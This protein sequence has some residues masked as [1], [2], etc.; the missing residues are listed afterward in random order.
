[1]ENNFQSNGKGRSQR[2]WQLLISM[3]FI[4][5]MGIGQMWADQTWDFTQMSDADKTAY[6]AA[7]AA[8]TW[9]SNG[10]YNSQF[11]ANNGVWTD[12][13]STTITQIKNFKFKRSGSNLGTG[14]VRVYKNASGKSDGY[15]GY[16]NG[17]VHIG[18]TA[19][20]GDTVI[21][22]YFN[23]ESS[24]TKGYVLTGLKRI[25]DNATTI[26][27]AARTATVDSL[28]ATATAV[29]I[30]AESS[31]IRLYKLELKN[32]VSCTK[33]TAPVSLAVDSK[34]HNTATLSWDPLGAGAN[35]YKIALVSASGAGT[36]DWKDWTSNTY[37]AKDL[38]PET[39]YTFKVKYKGSGEGVCD[40]SDEVTKSFT[41]DPD[42]A[43]TTYKVTLVPAGGTISDATGWTLNA[44]N[45]EKEVSEGTVLSLPTFTKENRTFKTWRNGVP[46]DVTSPIT[47][48]AD[49]TLTAVWN[50]TVDNVIYYWAGAQGGA[51]EVGGTATGSTD[52][53]I[54]VAKS[55]YYCLQINGNT[56]YDKYV[57][58]TL[59][60]EEKVKTGDKIRY[61]GFYTNTGTKN[62]AIKMRTS[63]G[64]A[65]FTGANLPRVETTSP[66]T[67]TY[68][69]ETDG[70]NASAVQITRHQTQTSSWIPM[71]QI[72]RPTLVEEVNVRTVTFNYN[73]GGTT[74]N[75]TVNVASGSAVYAPFV[76][77]WAH[78][79]F[80][81]WKLNSSAYDFSTPVTSDITLVADW[82]QLYT[83][84]FSA[85]DGS[86]DAP[87]AVADKAQGETFKV[88]ANTFTAPDESKEFDKWNDGTNDYAPDAT[89]TVGTANVV[90]TAQWKSASA[91]YTVIFKDGTTE[92]GVKKFNVST[93]PSDAEIDKAKPLYTFAAWQKDAADIALD[94]AFWATV[95][96]D[97]EVTLTAR[98]AKAYAAN[99]DFEAF[100]DAQGTSGNWQ[101]YLSTNNY[102][103]SNTADVSLDDQG[104]EKPAD[105][106][107]KMKNHSGA[108]VSF[109][110][111]ADKLVLVK[112]GRVN[113]MS[114]SVDG[115]TNYS[116]L[117]GAA[118]SAGASVVNYLYNAVEAEYRLK[119]T[120]D[121]Y[122]IIQ[123]IT[124]TNPYQVSYDSHGA[125]AIAAQYGT[126]SV[127]L[128]T[129]VNGTG[130][131][132]G[133]YTAATEG[134]KIGNAG[135]SYTPTANITLHAQWETVSSDNT[136]SD[137]KVDGVTVAGFD[138][139]VHIYYLGAYEY[140]QHPEITSAT[141]TAEAAGAT[142]AISNTPV[143]YVDATNDFWYVQ[144]NV[145]PV[146]GTPIGYNQVRYTVKPKQ[147]VSL[148]KVVIPNG[149]GN[150]QNVAEA[151]ITGYI[152]GTAVQK[153]ESGTHKLGSKGHYI[154]ITLASGTFQENDI[155]NV[156]IE[157]ITGDKLR[158]FSENT[159]AESK[160]VAQSTATMVAG[161][162]TV[163]LDATST[164]SLYLRRG[165]DAEDYQK[166]W[167]PFVG[168]FE[169][170]R[171]MP[172]FIESF[173]LAGVAGIIDQ[174]LKTISVEVPYSTDITSLT[175][176]IKAWANGGATLDKTGAQN[177]S[178]AVVYKVTSA[179]AE[180]G[181]VAYTV[182]VTKAEASHVAT[183]SDIKLDG[184]SL[185]GFDPATLSYNVELEKGTLA[186][187]A[188]TYTAA[189]GAT[190]IPSSE[191]FPGAYNLVV[192]AEDGTT[193]Q[194]YTINF[195]V[196][197]KNTVVIFDGTAATQAEALKASPDATGA[198]W[199]LVGLSISESA[200]TGYNY[201]IATGGQT[202]T[203][204]HIVVTVP[205]NYLP[206][207][208]ITHVTNSNGSA[209]N[210][211][212]G[213]STTR[214]ASTEA[215]LFYVTSSDISNPSTG[216]SAQLNEETTYYIHSDQSIN[217]LKIAL[218]LEPLAPKAATPTLSGL[219]DLAACTLG[220]D[221]LTV[222]ASDLDG[223][224]AHYQWYKVV[225][226]DDPDEAVG[227]DANT[228]APAVA[229]N[230][231]VVV[232]NQKDGCRDNSKKSDE[233]TVSVKAATEI[234]GY[235]N[236]NGPEGAT[237]K[238]ISVTATGTGTLH[239]VWYTCNDEFGTNPVAVDPANDAATLSGLT[240]PSGIQYYKV[241]V[242]GECGSAEQ[243]LFA[244]EWADVELE[245][246]TNSVVWN[247]H[248][249][250]N[251]AAWTGITDNVDIA[252]TSVLANVNY[253]QIP[254]VADFHS[255]MLKAVVGTV[256]TRMRPSTDNGCYQGDGIMFHTTVPG[257][258]H[259]T[260]RGTG[261][262]AKVILT[263]AGTTFDEYSG[264]FTRSAGV[265]VAAGDVTISSNAAMRIQKIEFY[266]LAH[267]RT[268]GYNAGDLG[269]VCLE[270]A[271]FIDGANLYEL[272][273]L[274]E[275]GYL[276]FDEITT[277]E[278]EAGKPYLFEV[279]N[280][281]KISFYKPVGAAHT[282]TE[283]TTGTKGMIG[284][285]S[286]TTLYQNVTENYYYFSGRHI[287][288]VNDFT[289]AIPIPGHRCY[290]DYDVLKN[291]QASPNPAPGRRRVTLGVQ[292]TQVTTD[293]NNVGSDDVQC[294]K[295]MIDGQLYILRGEK[296]Y[297]ATGRLVK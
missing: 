190:V 12:V 16:N 218:L 52:G 243:I 169:V 221:E 242:T 61:T 232:T 185:E 153:L 237:G 55:G 85:G 216:T 75:T 286:G 251:P 17:N 222:T 104:T 201:K 38:T 146:S 33:P 164:N 230:Y 97:A 193:K 262:D 63:G 60:G 31:K 71:L 102:A 25:K 192:T 227:T 151:N 106:G 56:S 288:K 274:D 91:K 199:S 166:G 225:E 177:F 231:Y 131:F 29:D 195:T 41:T 279:T 150:D 284:T 95:A 214:P 83:I 267:E 92:L 8:W 90:L 11:T 114:A 47:V 256:Q 126:P 27:V 46:A 107:L 88:P 290:I 103:I 188:V 223:G 35:G 9:N 224:T 15:L 213:T 253:G 255:A 1:M 264:G 10:Y 144:A 133:W 269:T 167:N 105:K 108:Y 96:K 260:Y 176:T 80:N 49:V 275:H 163:L 2:V 236:A 273:G 266:A 155:V 265:E 196:S 134:T 240:I 137:L 72:L 148:I 30:K 32:P 160:V 124:I 209:R 3:L 252:A 207:F 244:R 156:N 154:G 159:A 250:Q 181:E 135:A 254:N 84:S 53:L 171:L 94:D 58:I 183:L 120:A 194:T 4:L 123:S 132:K 282:D 276:A 82:T 130:T 73:D 295:V 281:S 161:V 64:T 197:T 140:G 22:S 149:T 138:P 292:G 162:N 26:Q 257:I 277:G 23:N 283:V 226:G 247:W 246:V 70:I 116:A 198:T 101:N 66:R 175:P 51:T 145:T 233:V 204:K 278:L 125:D 89:Y 294:T 157:T 79:R 263:I 235:I 172:S 128:P 13:I 200:F 115:G 210:A 141:P 100:I 87:A 280:P 170:Q 293:I 36:F 40:F 143:H 62:A 19:A 152:G 93:N 86:G 50:A 42:P 258:V 139:D 238:Q 189:T 202:G 6:D 287:W 187:P 81:G 59:S 291:A 48:T 270:D 259:V 211:L 261:N 122:N 118:S 217:F 272:A 178:S 113:G 245:D 215:A 271:T 20:I 234:T 168:Y 206:Q 57:E 129:P 14:T 165:T 147:G 39:E 239:Y 184:V 37:T 228:Y 99:I 44:G 21:V 180:D 45:Y 121:A 109:N 69:I 54:N 110:V 182:N 241:V 5:T 142:V 205:A 212:V 43:A 77:I 173:E 248:K 74:A 119:T 136:L 7:T 186:Y 297:D 191:A 208:V 285:F 220:T 28:I 158:V 179:Y 98:W 76:P 24:S 18:F 117:D 249:T 112:M 67:D 174:D 296:M 68:T 219:A 229:G 111:H 65:I 78:H 127:T 268:S 203:S 289:V 34:T